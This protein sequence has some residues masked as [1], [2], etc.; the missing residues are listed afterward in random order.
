[1][2][3]GMAGLG[4]E[5]L[6]GVKREWADVARHGLDEPQVGLPVPRS[7]GNDVTMYFAPPDAPEPDKKLA[8][9]S[10]LRPGGTGESISIYCYMH[11]CKI[12]KRVDKWPTGLAIQQWLKAGMDLPKGID[13]KQRHTSM[14]PAVG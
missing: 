12:C 10:V 8:R 3:D 14:W 11:R 5:S 13:G 7:Q 1:M 6:S 4:P 9:Q 2:P